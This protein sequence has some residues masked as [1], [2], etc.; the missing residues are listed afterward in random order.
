VGDLSIL[1]GFSDD[2]TSFADRLLRVSFEALAK[3]PRLDGVLSCER[4]PKGDL[5]VF[6]LLLGRDYRLSI[7]KC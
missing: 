7:R 1:Q 2:A 4:P 6:W 3:F 5:F